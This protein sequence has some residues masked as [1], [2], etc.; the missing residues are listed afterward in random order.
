MRKWLAAQGWYWELYYGFGFQF[1]WL[2][3]PNDREWRLILLEGMDPPP[4]RPGYKQHIVR[5]PRIV[6]YRRLPLC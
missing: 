5:M 4:E 6:D 2:P 1:E 3:R